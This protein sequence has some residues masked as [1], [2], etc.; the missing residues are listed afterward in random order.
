VKGPSAEE[1]QTDLDP[2]VAT[3]AAAPFA[4]VAEMAGRDGG[5]QGYVKAIFF[6]DLDFHNLE[7]KDKGIAFANLGAR[8]R[9]SGVAREK[10]GARSGGHAHSV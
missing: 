9:W 3:S 7:D 2:Q 4:L 1:S 10:Q 5:F 6:E 8:R